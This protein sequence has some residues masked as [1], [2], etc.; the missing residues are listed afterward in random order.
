MDIGLGFAKTLS[1]KTGK[2]YESDEDAIFDGLLFR[3]FNKEEGIVGLYPTLKFIKAR[4]GLIQIRTGS[5]SVYIDMRAKKTREKFDAMYDTP[6]IKWLKDISVSRK[7][8]PIK[9]T[10]ICIDLQI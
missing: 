9:G 1:Q 4:H 5:Y 8:Y 3:F 7:I 2:Q 6:T 10:H